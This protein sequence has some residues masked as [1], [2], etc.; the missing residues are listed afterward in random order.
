MNI[1]LAYI[2][3]GLMVGLAGCGSAIGTSISGSAT[4]GALKKKK[5]GFGSYLILTALPGTQGLYGFAAFFLFNSQIQ[6]L[7]AAT[8]TGTDLTLLQGAA[9]LGAGIAMGLACL[10]SGIKQGQVCANGVSAVGSGYDVFGNTLV[11][12]VF[13]E[14]YAIISFAGAFLILGVI[15]TVGG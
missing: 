15:Q 8:P 6:E 9:T 13:P 2:G 14:L 10:I 7:M 11:M 4:V 3:L 1:I 12:A 5:E